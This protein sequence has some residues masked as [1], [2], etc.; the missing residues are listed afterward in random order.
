[1][2]NFIQAQIFA[3]NL[4]LIIIQFW[5]KHDSNLA[6]YLISLIDGSSNTR[7]NSID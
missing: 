7:E 3:L 5:S 6:T 2:F 1:M 4:I